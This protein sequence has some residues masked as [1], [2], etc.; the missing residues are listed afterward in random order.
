MKA[1]MT[2]RIDRLASRL[3][4][5]RGFAMIPA[6][7]AVFVG[8]LISL[9]A[10]T[11]ASS[12]IRLQ[13]T[14]R[15][16]KRAYTAAQTGLADYV[17]RLAAN[18]NYWSYC[19][20]DPQSSTTRLAGINDRDVGTGSGAPPRSWLPAPAFD[21]VDDRAM[22]YQYTIDLLPN[23]G[24]ATC[25]D[26]AN[27]AITMINPANGT[28]R[29]RVTGRAG[30][31]VPTSATI[32][33]D[34]ANP[35]VFVARNAASVKQ[36]RELRWKRRSVVADFRRRGFLDFAYFTD[37]EGQ[38]PPLQPD[39][40]WAAVNCNVWYRGVN[41]RPANATGSDQCVELVFLASDR[42]NGP[43]HTNDSIYAR[44]GATFGTPSG[45]DR[46]EISADSTQCPVRGAATGSCGTT[47]PNFQGTYIDGAAVLEL[48]EANEELQVYGEATDGMSKTGKTRIVMKSNG[49]LDITNNGITQVDVNPPA[50]G[51][52]YVKSGVGCIQYNINQNYWNPPA[53]GTVEVQGTY[54]VPLT[55]AAEADIVITDDVVK[56][57]TAPNAVLGL[58]ANDYVR[59]RHVT[60]GDSGGDR[61]Y[62]SCTNTGGAPRVNVI[63]AAILAIKHS[64]MVDQW[65]CGNNLGTLTVRGALT[66]KYRGAVG[67]T[68][69]SSSN[70]YTKDYNYDYRLRYLTPP[71]F[72]TPSLTGWRISR[73]REQSPACRCNEP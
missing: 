69:G 45:N 55:I 46:I 7:T 26:E 2:T 70:G 9:G 1:S 63:E 44:N 13:Q 50:N 62:N 14:D 40:A 35:S 49:R 43:F 59:V 36:W 73:Y 12:D 6:I 65:A 60:N 8:S 68:G 72:L 24:Y 4:S 23:P 47:S 54:T 19:D 11:A 18:S 15:W 66:Q 22:T 3:R 31:P 61:P 57:S 51:V 5:Q 67:R 41:G 34:P 38:D 64:F 42:I 52:I 21:S 27:R 56:A 53:C 48:P 58:I 20:Q 16:Q 17:Q 25:K 29:V 39:P 28:F 37:I 33:P 32:N 30:P 10:W 71:F